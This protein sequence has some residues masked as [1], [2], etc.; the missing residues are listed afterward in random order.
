MIKKNQITYAHK[1][2]IYFF[3]KSN[4]NLESLDTTMDKKKQLQIDIKMIRIN[5][6]TFL[7][8]F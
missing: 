4:S 5:F 7:D 1:C 3:L 8:I 6:V 2:K